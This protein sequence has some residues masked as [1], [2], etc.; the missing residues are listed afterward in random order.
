[1]MI[2]SKTTAT[3]VFCFILISSA[4]PPAS[5]CVASFGYTGTTAANSYD[6]ANHVGATAA[7]VG[8][9]GNNPS[10]NLGPEV[11][12]I[13]A[14]TG[15]VFINLKE[16]IFNP[17]P[18]AVSS[19]TH[20]ERGPASTTKR[21]YA[22]RGEYKARLDA[23]FLANDELFQ[24]NGGQRQVFGL[25]IHDEANNDCVENW[26]LHLASSYV[27]QK[28]AAAEYS[29][30]YVAA[31]YGL[32]NT[33]GGPV[34]NGLPV[35]PTGVIDKFPSPLDLI[36]IIA[37]DIFNPANDSDPMNLNAETWSTISGK[38]NQAL[39]P[40]QKTAS[41]IKGFCDDNDPTEPAWGIQCPPNWTNWWKLGVQA[42]NWYNYLKN[43]PRNVF[44][45]AFHWQDAGSFSGT[46]SLFTIWNAHS[47]L[48]PN[49]S[50]PML[51]QP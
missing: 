13:V 35:T 36:G 5:A 11:S 51:Y 7:Y 44:L 39:R 17:N 19:C 21:F 46:E 34:S 30:I 47:Q 43:D 18:I 31:G 15:P 28:L 25:I 32:R 45:L 1:M 9:P 4:A 37:Y 2:P 14:N 29:P 20:Y 8:A 26:V 41:V 33:L 10:Y 23:W 40:G 42:T 49:C 24:W 12:Q 27:R 3:C 22:I 6:I 50:V 48:T 16:I 38:L